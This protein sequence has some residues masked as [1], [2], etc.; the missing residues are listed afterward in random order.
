MQMSMS[1]MT[2]LRRWIPSGVA[3][4]AAIADGASVVAADHDTIVVSQG[5]DVL[6]LDP[7]LDTSPIGINVFRNVFDGLTRIDADGSVSPLLAESWTTSEDTKT[8]EFTIRATA[9]F[10]NG[11]PVTAEDI[12][13][14]YQHLAAELKSPVRTYINKVKAVEHSGANEVRFTLSEPFAPFDR[15]V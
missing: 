7:T 2:F 4:V 1:R 3:F 9:K 12:I 14:S 8:W 5:S 6:T 10:R 13:W 15:Q 11:Q